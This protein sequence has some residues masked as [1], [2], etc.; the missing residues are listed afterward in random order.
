[1]MI[2]CKFFRSL[3]PV[4]LGLGLL[5]CTQIFAQEI[6]TVQDFETWSSVG[7]EYKPIHR[8]SLEL[9]EQVRLNNNSQNLNQYFTQLSLSYELS[10][11][12]EFSGGYRWI[13]ASKKQDG[14]SINESANRYHLGVVYKHTFK[15]ASFSYR[16]R[17]QN[18]SF[19]DS[20]SSNNQFWRFKTRV[21]YNIKN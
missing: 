19:L 10:K 14:V 12:F 8:M 11:H 13:T 18:K 2:K 17:F 9:Q 7:L 3:S 15:R 16:L 20:N 5:T 21:K 1:M 6:K 4:F